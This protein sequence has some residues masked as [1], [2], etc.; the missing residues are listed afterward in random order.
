MH[1]ENVSFISLGSRGGMWGGAERTKLNRTPELNPH[2]CPAVNHQLL[3]T[4]NP[5]I[6][7]SVGVIWGNT[8]QFIDPGCSYGAVVLE[9][10]SECED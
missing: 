5:S 3:L 6:K 7:G 9:K 10:S 8:S 1:P 4:R 2:R